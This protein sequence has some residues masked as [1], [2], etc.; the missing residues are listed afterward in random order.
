MSNEP[1]F[2]RRINRDENGENR[3]TEGGD[4]SHCPSPLAPL[5]E[6]IKMCVGSIITERHEELRELI[7][8]GISI[9][10]DGNSPE[11]YIAANVEKR[12]VILGLA[13]L[14]RVWAYTY[15]Y[16]AALDL[17]PNS[18]KGTV[19]DITSIDEFQPARELARWA[20]ECEREKYQSPWPFGLPRPD[21]DDGSDDRIRTAKHFFLH[22]VCFLIL[23]EIG[24]IH[25]QHPPGKFVDAKT[26]HKFE[27]EADGWAADFML[28]YWE[29]AGRGQ[30][31]FIGRCTGISFG[32]AMLAG[33]EFYHHAAQDDH[34]TIAER[35]L[36]FFEKY[37]PEVTGPPSAVRDFPFH[38]ASVIL[39]THFLNAG[40][41]FDLTK[42]YGDITNYLIAAHR[43][44]NEHKNG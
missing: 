34:P 28:Q 24:H 36:R 12:E 25:F 2:R 10:L 40:I 35:L 38:L 37:N 4:I 31:D 22:A 33:V 27:N 13:A 21:I 14:E 6:S 17:L 11:F 5:L 29:K 7:D 41:P 19:I 26:S 1:L 32:L 23:H 15:F 30:K 39:H 42:D 16:L 3:I 9:G 8:S 18:P 20:L 44:L 43:A